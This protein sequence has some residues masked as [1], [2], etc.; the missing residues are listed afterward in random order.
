MC[1]H[2]SCV[3]QILHK[4]Q[5]TVDIQYTHAYTMYTFINVH[6]QYNLLPK[7]QCRQQNRRIYNTHKYNAPYR[8]VDFTGVVYYA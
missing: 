8:E 2:L 5:Y 1:E 6:K 3:V 7:K 4:K